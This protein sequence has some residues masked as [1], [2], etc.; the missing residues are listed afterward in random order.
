MKRCLIH[1]DSVLLTVWEAQDFLTSL[2]Y[3]IN[4]APNNFI[5][6]KP[7]QFF[8]ERKGYLDHVEGIGF[9]R[10]CCRYHSGW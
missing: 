6:T 9:L 7:F 8:F 3:T 10:P 5:A 2:S 1:G 4:L